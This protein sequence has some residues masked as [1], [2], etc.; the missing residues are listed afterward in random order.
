MVKAVGYIDGQISDLADVRIPVADRGFLYGDSV[1]E[2]FRTYSGIPFLFDE[3]Y[4]RLLNSARLIEM[5]IKQSKQEIISAV[6]RTVRASLPVTGE[7]VYTRYQITR[8]E[9]PIDLNPGLSLQ[10]RLVIIVKAAPQ[11][12]Q[13]FYDKG[14]TLAV[15]KLRRNSVNSLNPNIKGGNYLNNIMALGEAKKLG[16]DDCLML[17]EKGQVAECSNSNV[18]FVVGG[19]LV[20]P[21]G[22]NLDGLTRR[23][24]ISLLTDANIEVVQRP[25]HNEELTEVTECFVTS[26][27]REL[28]PV[29]ALYLVDGSR[30]D[31][32][33]GGGQQ[34]RQ[35]M[36]IYKQMLKDFVK[37]N[38]ENAWF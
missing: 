29:H 19:K 21:A 2:V 23:S 7:D 13:E 14:L 36:N 9:G 22:G 32:Q 34:T 20:T 31:F 28:M 27:T 4:Q 30:I 37:E 15:P 38:K 25:I 10:T 1:Y 35:A 33:A 17:D 24:L 5:D 18:W 26:A 11:W 12:N 3:H 6:K 8:G 16:A